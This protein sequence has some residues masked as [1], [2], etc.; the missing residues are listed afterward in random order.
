VLSRAELS[1]P[2]P[3]SVLQAVAPQKQAR[4]L[5]SADD[6]LRF[7]EGLEAEQTLPFKNRERRL[8]L[9]R[10][11]LGQPPQTLVARPGVEA[12]E[13]GHATF[14]LGLGVGYA[15]QSGPSQTLSA[16]GALHDYL[17][18]PRGYQR[19]AQLAMFNLAVRFADQ[20]RELALQHL[21]LVDIVS[22]APLE[23]WVHSMSWKVWFGV[24]N[25]RELGCDRPDSDRQGWRCL[26]AGVVTGGGGAVRF[27]P[28][29]RFLALALAETDL[30]A[31]PAFTTG[32]RYRVG[33]GGEGMLVGEASDRLR[34]LLD[35]R[36]AL[37]LL[38][39]R[40]ANLRSQVAMSL[41]LSH[42]W[43]LRAAVTTAGTWAEAGLT[44]YAF[45]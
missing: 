12:P 28:Q 39:D 41:S 45:F 32:R 33:L 2:L 21:D 3:V 16:R 37:Y 25:A 30:G 20:R 15:G 5:D 34:F 35:A 44:L 7:R 10:G 1:E 36:A 26:Y 29:R 8:L 31:G 23:R 18:P 22:A 43:E 11:R 42:T 6:Y 27:G 38:G 4:I 9:A 14:R 17:D 40:R 24:D 13:V 19:D